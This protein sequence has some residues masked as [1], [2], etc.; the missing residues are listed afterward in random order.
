MY[1]YEALRE[2]S[3]ERQE[4]LRGEAGA[5]RLAH[6]ARARRHHRRKRL[7]LAGAYELLL[8]ARRQAARAREGA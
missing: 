8:G 2:R 3:R 4:R 1:D 7:A 5:E 6:E